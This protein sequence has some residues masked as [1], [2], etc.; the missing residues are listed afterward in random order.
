MLG[1]AKRPCDSAARHGS[2]LVQPV[3]EGGDHAE[4]G[5][6]AA[7]RPEQVGI[8]RGGGDPQAAVAGHDVDGFEIVAREAV[9]ASEPPDAAAEGQT[10]DPG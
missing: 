7:H 1:A 5:A 6:S 2:N 8:L 4:V 3:L 9:L 10:G